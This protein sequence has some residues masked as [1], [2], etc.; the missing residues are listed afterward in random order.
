M[1]VRAKFYVEKVESSIYFRN[2]TDADG[3]NIKNEH[4]AILTEKVEMRTIKLRPVYSAEPGTENKRFW[5]ASPAGLIE[6]GTINPAAWE[7]FPLGAE[8]Y[9]DFTQADA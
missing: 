7:Y 8:V 1:T 4:G 6:L 2:K 3:A 9:I 5:D